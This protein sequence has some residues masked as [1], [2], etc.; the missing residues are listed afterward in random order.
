MPTFGCLNRKTKRKMVRWLLLFLGIWVS[1]PSFAEECRVALVQAELAWGDV[2]KN[3]EAFDARIDR[4]RDCDVI[5]FPELFT[6]GCEMKRKDTGHTVPFQT[7]AEVATRFA[8][9]LHR[10]QAWAARSGALVIGSTVYEEEG[11]FYNRLLAV[12]P[13]GDYRYYDKHNCFKKGG[14]SPGER[15]LVLEWKGQ[16]IATYICYDLRFAEWSRNEGQ[17]DVAVYIANWPDSRRTDWNRL[18]AER[19]TENQAYVIGVN[20]AGTDPYGIRY[21]GDS[22]LV[23]PD[24]RVT[25]QCQPYE[26]EIMKVVLKSK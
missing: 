6:V 8:E 9:V 4:C 26:E 14:Y 25:A 10:M 20:C 23:A 15:Q 17:Y 16:R 3:L 24:G 22:Q 11:R 13:N 7:K 1:Y 2:T 18:L 12:Y 5:L 19:A 21:A